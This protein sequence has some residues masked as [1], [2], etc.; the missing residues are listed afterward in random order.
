MYEKSNSCL[1][2]EPQLRMLRELVVYLQKINL[3]MRWSKEW[4]DKRLRLVYPVIVIH[5]EV[6]IIGMRIIYEVQ[7]ISNLFSECTF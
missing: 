7:Q 6:M 1:I 3:G 2:P 5:I 4:D